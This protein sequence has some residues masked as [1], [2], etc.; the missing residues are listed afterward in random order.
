MP[1]AVLTL[2]VFRV[3]HSY[4]RFQWILAIS[5]ATHL[6]ADRPV[7][8]VGGD[9]TMYDQAR[10]DTTGL[11][12]WWEDRPDGIGNSIGLTNMKQIQFDQTAA[13][14]PDQFEGEGW[15][16]LVGN[17]DLAMKATAYNLKLLT[18]DSAAL[19]TPDVK[20]SQPINQ[21]LSSS[22]NALGIEDRSRSVAE[23][24]STFLG[25]EIEHGQSTVKPEG[26]FELADRILRGTGAYR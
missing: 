23:G 9:G 1:I 25:N 3:V 11:R 12:E 15:S 18:D 8:A 5:N 2:H 4:N 7:R 22:Y 17:D 14:F 21:F 24:E 20:A 19:A 10:K 13:K 16:D 26:T 6:A